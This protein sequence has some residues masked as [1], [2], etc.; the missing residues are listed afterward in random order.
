[1]T[2]VMVAVVGGC[3]PLST[4][5]YLA[6]SEDDSA[7]TGSMSVLVETRSEPDG[8][9]LDGGHLRC[10]NDLL[11]ADDDGHQGFLIHAETAVGGAG[12]GGAYLSDG[13]EVGWAAIGGRSFAGVGG[14]L[15]WGGYRMT[16]LEVVGGVHV[17]LAGVLALD[18][19]AAGRIPREDDDGVSSGTAFAAGA[20][21]YLAGAALSARIV[22]EDGHEYV[23]LGIGLAHFFDDH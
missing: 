1:M 19:E 18:G 20:R 4:M 9:R 16:S 15:R 12:D 8:G 22:R 3:A 10:T 17:L 5:G 23:M 11:G 2:A 13:L 21:L 6:S 14:G 7:R